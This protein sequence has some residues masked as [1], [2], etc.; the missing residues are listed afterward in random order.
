M[1][2][3][4]FM[5]LTKKPMLSILVSYVFLVLSAT[6]FARSQWPTPK[7]NI[8]LFWSYGSQ[9]YQNLPQIFGNI[10]MFIPIGFLLGAEV[11]R[12]CIPSGIL[13]SVVIELVQL[14]TRR[15]TFE[16][17]DIL[18]NTIGL[19][20]G[21]SLLLLIKHVLKDLTREVQ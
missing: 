13:F 15:G 16:F 21:Y 3:L 8:Q 18:H 17:D 9:F 2:G 12:K 14:F 20:I 19:L 7:Y 10:V 1:I 4:T 5:L 11:G 6:I